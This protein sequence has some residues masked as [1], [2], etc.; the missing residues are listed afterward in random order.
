MEPSPP[1]AMMLLGA[2]L[3]DTVILTS[4]TTTERDRVVV[5]Y[6][7]RVL[8]LD[9][10]EYG[11][12]MFEE[13]SDVSDVSAEEI[14]SRDAKE[15]H[16]GSGHQICIAQI[17]VV[18]KSLLERS[19]ELVE[20]MRAARDSKGL[21]LYALMV[22]DVVTKGTDLLVAGDDAGVA[23]TFGVPA[24]DGHIELP[25]VMSRKKEVAPKLLGGL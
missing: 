23:R 24:Q 13:T 7:E 9:A 2:V 17:E 25:G 10:T 6:L 22:T 11:R 8:A 21:H 3:S 5:E 4:A 18:G 16:T 12:E 1:T 15:Y 14:I 20:A 19:A